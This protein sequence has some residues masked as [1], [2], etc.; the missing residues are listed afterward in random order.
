MLDGLV[1]ILS[2]QM[3]QVV[4]GAKLSATDLA[5]YSTAAMLVGAGLSFLSRVVGDL[6]LPWISSVKSE[7]E[8]YQR[9][10][11]ILGT[12]IT[13]CAVAVFAP[14]AVVGTD[15]TV[16]I[17]GQNYIGPKSMMVWLALA[18]ALGFLRIW[19][20]VTSL[21][22]GDARNLMFSGIVQSFGIIFVVILI[23]LGAGL[24]GAAL[25]AAIAEF[26]ATAVAFIRLQRVHGGYLASGFMHL[27]VIIIAFL[28]AIS[29]G[30]EFDSLSNRI[31][32]SVL[33]FAVPIFFGVGTIVWEKNRI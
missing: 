30:L 2:Q 27:I 32:F 25:A 7:R 15:L 1:I 18:S 17:F 4:I 21:S 26:L 14:L 5:I 10:H 19:P 6:S 29:V 22:L 8:I 13:S 9:R 23:E 16:L 11:K 20:I 12:V 24:P 33:L 28:I 3:N 31:L